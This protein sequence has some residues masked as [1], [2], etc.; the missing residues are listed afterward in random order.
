MK[1]AIILK[2]IGLLM[3]M[4]LFW[5]GFLTIVDIADPTENHAW[6]AISGGYF[7]AMYIG[8]KIR[9]ELLKEGA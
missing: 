3:I 5:C 2:N 6:A 1:V 8:F 7:M 4:A 9:I